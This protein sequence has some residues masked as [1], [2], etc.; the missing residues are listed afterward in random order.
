MLNRLAK[1]LTESADLNPELMRDVTRRLKR[2]FIQQRANARNR[3]VSW[4]LTWDEWRDWWLATGRVDERGRMRG[5][6]VMGRPYDSGPY[7]IGNLM[8]LRAEDNVRQQNELRAGE[9]TRWLR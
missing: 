5:Q 6:W 2:R 1:V 4:E 8:C 7:A 3:G 9:Y